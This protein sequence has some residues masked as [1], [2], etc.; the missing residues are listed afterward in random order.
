MPK[1]HEAEILEQLAITAA[2]D[3]EFKR[4]SA[5]FA[6]W[7]FRHARAEDAVRRA[8]EQVELVFARLYAAYRRQHTDAKE[9]DCK[10]YI[11]RS[12]SHKAAVKAV[13]IAKFNRDILK[14]A[15][16]A[17]EMRRDMLVQL[18]ADARSELSSTDLSTKVRKASKVV[19]RT[20]EEK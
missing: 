11:R 15:V 8:E 13:R 4:Q 5:Y 3:R 2:L 7:A 9:N 6:L 20:Y 18:G 10:S 14:A 19:R 12:K 16:R 17:F 1:D